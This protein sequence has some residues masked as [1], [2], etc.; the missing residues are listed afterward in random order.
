MAQGTLRDAMCS[1]DGGQLEENG[2]CTCVAEL[3]CCAPET[4]TALLTSHAP[5]QNKLKNSSSGRSVVQLCNHIGKI[6]PWATWMFPN[7]CGCL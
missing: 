6:L 2:Y 7:S 5:V 4:S 3:L 1:L